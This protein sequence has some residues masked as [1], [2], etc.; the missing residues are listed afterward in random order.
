LGRCSGFREGAGRQRAKGLTT[1]TQKSA[2]IPIYAHTTHTTQASKQADDQK[3]SRDGSGGGGGDGFLRHE[4][5]G[6]AALANPGRVNDG[7]RA[8]DTPLVAAAWKHIHSLVVWLL[9]EKGAD[10]NVI[11]SDGGLHVAASL[12]ILIALLDRGAGELLVVPPDG[13]GKFW[14]RR[15]SGT[16]AAR[17][18]R[19]SH[20]Q[21]A[22][23][24]RRHS[25][26]YG[27][28]MRG[29]T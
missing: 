20:C 21:H 18:A 16:P 11:G 23:W 27:L 14:N 19:P 15:C 4:R 25:S 26:S 13:A 3:G 7:D 8:G 28:Y 17:R 9:D 6:A 2:L 1:L 10:V 29:P 5:G 12:D 22:R 24:Q